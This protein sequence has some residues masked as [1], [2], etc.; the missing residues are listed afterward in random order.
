MVI[1]TQDHHISYLQNIFLVI[2]LGF[3][4]YEILIVRLLIFVNGTNETCNISL[5]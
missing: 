4:Y 2:L 5:F 1:S 3:Y